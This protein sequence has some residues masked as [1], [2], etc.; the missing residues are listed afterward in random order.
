MPEDHKV[1]EDRKDI[2]EP[3]GLQVV[4]DQEDLKDLLLLDQEELK[5]LKDTQA[6]EAAE[7]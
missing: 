3:R 5:V 6:A 7:E 1:R 4:L 2:E